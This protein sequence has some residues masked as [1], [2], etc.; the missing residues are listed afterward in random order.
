MH[1]FESLVMKLNP[2]SMHQ[3]QKL[4]PKNNQMID[5]FMD[6]KKWQKLQQVDRNQFDRALKSVIQNW[7]SRRL[8]SP[9]SEF[10]EDKS[11]SRA[12]DR[13][14][15]IQAIFQ[16]KLSDKID[17]ETQ[18][19]DRGRESQRSRISRLSERLLDREKRAIQRASCDR[20]RKSSEQSRSTGL[21]PSQQKVLFKTHI[22]VSAG[23]DKTP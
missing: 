12:P 22:K 18:G 16:S 19:A 14:T 17:V 20:H 8:P 7:P 2:F 11:T 3:I 5:S 10:K 23:D 1:K 13:E 9:M 21:A 6:A 15:P 4:S